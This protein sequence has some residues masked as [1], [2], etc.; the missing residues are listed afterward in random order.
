M[1]IAALSILHTYV[2]AKLNERERE[3]EKERMRESGRDG[4]LQQA[5]NNMM[6]I[7]FQN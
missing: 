2:Y 7:H 4:K 3:R 6:Q 1:E 5:F